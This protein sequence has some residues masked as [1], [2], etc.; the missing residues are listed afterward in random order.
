MKLLVSDN[1]WYTVEHYLKAIDGSNVLYETQAYSGNAGDETSAISLT[2]DGYTARTIEQQEILE[3]DSTVVKVYY[4]K[5]PTVEGFETVRMNGEYTNLAGTAV[6]AEGESIKKPTATD[7]E[8]AWNGA[9]IYTG[10]DKLDSTLEVTSE[11]AYSGKYSLTYTSPSSGWCSATGIYIAIP[12]AMKAQLATGDKIT[13]KMKFESN[14]NLFFTDYSCWKSF[15][16][17]GGYTS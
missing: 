5:L 17:S 10:A 6:W 2:I 15:T 7:G 9:F 16:K 12:E 11:D 8:S 14:G 4:D 3:D 1:P 13:L